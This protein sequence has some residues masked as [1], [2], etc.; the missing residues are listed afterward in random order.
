[1]CLKLAFFYPLIFFVIGWLLGGNGEFIGIQ[2]FVDNSLMLDRVIFL[3]ALTLSV[4]ALQRCIH[5]RNP[6]E[7]AV[8]F[9]LA[10]VSIGAGVSVGSGIG[11]GV[12]AFVFAFVLVFSL[13]IA[14]V[15]ASTFAIA[16][17]I[18]FAGGGAFSG[19][20]AGF[21]T[22]FGAFAFAVFFTIW[23]QKLQAEGSKIF[24]WFVFY[25]F[26]TAVSAALIDFLT[27]LD[28]QFNSER[29]LILLFLVVLP[30]QNVWLDWLSL[31][32]TRGLLYGIA[33]GKH[34]VVTAVIFGVLD[35][36]FA[37]LLM[38]TLIAL[39]VAVVSGFN[40]LVQKQLGQNLLDF[41]LLFQ[42]L[43]QGF[44]ADNLWVHLMMFSTLLPTLIHLGVL[45][46]A[47][48][49]YL[50]PKKS[51]KDLNAIARGDLETRRKA[52]IQ[53][54]LVTNPVF[55]LLF[56]VLAIAGLY[57]LLAANHAELGNMLLSWAVLIAESIDPMV[58]RASIFTGVIGGGV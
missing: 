41:N 57:S 28:A 49:L 16:F 8:S 23:F 58:D 2:F 6:V 14:A 35:I 21:L 46:F 53:H 55:V 22:F 11:V 42:Q 7:F 24:F 38:L 51:Q 25:F 47:T 44:S 54:F 40:I 9:T 1:M 37:L 15:V 19:V 27:P 18:S 4:F 13:A 26:Y 45:S 29:L 48:M 30:L 10:L 34:R 5:A 43:R 12:I 52:C 31:A 39:V 3:L 36:V 50:V 56:P 20:F 33:S 17:A 32:V